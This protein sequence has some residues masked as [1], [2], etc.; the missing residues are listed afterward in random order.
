[1]S[2]NEKSGKV[3]R[4]NIE[5]TNGII[6]TVDTVMIDDAPPWQ[7]GAASTTSWSASAIMISLLVLLRL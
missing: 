7:V 1:M 6:H 4:P 5:C 3:I 2:W